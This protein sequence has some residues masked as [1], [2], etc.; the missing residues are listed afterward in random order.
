MAL[1]VEE[2]HKFAFCEGYEDGLDSLDKLC[3]AAVRVVVARVGN[4]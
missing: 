1:V 2:R 4:E 3:N